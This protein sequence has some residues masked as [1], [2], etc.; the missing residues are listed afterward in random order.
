MQITRTQVRHQ[1]IPWFSSPLRLAYVHI[2]EIATKA[3]ISFNLILV[4]KPKRMNS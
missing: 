3:L 1:Y 4:L 2:V